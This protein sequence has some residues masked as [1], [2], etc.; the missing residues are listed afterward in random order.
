M[1]PY[2]E[3]EWTTIYHGDC[4][5]LAMDVSPDFVLTDPPYGINHDPGS[6]WDRIVGDD[7]PFDFSTLPQGV[8]LIT[9]GADHYMHQLPEGGGWIVWNKR[10]RVS[11]GL[12]GSDG[13]LAW[14]NVTTQ[15]RIFTQVWIPHT[16][17]TEGA[18]H[19]TQKPSELL[20]VLLDEFAPI[21]C[22]VF[23]PYMG[24]GSTLVAARK[25]GRKS[26]GIEIE[27]R[28]CESAV[29]RLAQGVLFGEVS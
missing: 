26:I 5:K 13:E 11:R 10:D 2:Y 6:A 28:Y 19:P 12:P 7:A 17:R 29:R 15:V 8:P 14:T 23:D 21:G 16:L 18:Y 9:F 22:T 4:R 24:S 25:T 27:E 1:I 3:D 20:A